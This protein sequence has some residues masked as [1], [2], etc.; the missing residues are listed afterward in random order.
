MSDRAYQEHFKSDVRNAWSSGHRNVCGVMPTGA[1][2]SY[3]VGEI[4]KEH[5]GTTVVI[6][7]RQELVGQLSMSIASNGVQ[8]QIIAPNNVRN[9]IMGE[10]LRELKV[11]MV[12]PNARVAVVGVDTLMRRTKQYARLMAETTMW[13]TDECHHIVRGNKWG[14]VCEMMPNA[15]GLGVTATPIRA[16]GLGLGR[17]A[18][19]VMDVMVEGPTMRELID[20]G[21]L[22]EYRIFAPPSDVDYSHV[23]TGSTGDLKFKQ[24]KSAV[25]ESHLVGDVVEHYK[26]LA[27]GKLGI[28]FATDVETAT[29]IATQFNAAGVPAEVVSAKTPA[30]IRAEIIRRFKARDLLQLVN[31]DL[32][33]EGFDLPAIEVV[34]MARRTLSYSLFSQQF[35]RALRPMPGKDCVSRDTDILTDRGLVKI[36]DITLDHKLWDGVSFVTHSGAVCKGVQKVI[37]FCGLTATPDHEVMTDEGWVTFNDAANRQLR[38][39]ETGIGRK[40]IRFDENNI[41]E[42]N[43]SGAPRW[44]ESTDGGSGMRGVLSNHDGYLQQPPPKAKQNRVQGLQWKTADR[45]PEVVIPESTGAEGS[46]RKPKQQHVEKLRRAWNKIQFHIGKLWCAMDR[47]EFRGEQRTTDRPQRQQRSLRAWESQ[48]DESTHQHEQHQEAGDSEYTAEIHRVQGKIPQRHVCGCHSSATDQGDVR[49]RN[50]KEME[51]TIV[52]TEREVW[53]IHDAGPLQRYTAGGLLVHNCALII[54]H[55]GNVRLHGLPDKERIWSLDSREKRPACK[56]P[57][58]DIPLRY[59]IECTQP[60]ERILV[61]CPWCGH[62]PVP[63]RRDGPEHVDGDLHELTPD[64]LAAMRSDVEAA[65]ES[66]TAV[67][68][69]MRYAGAPEVAWRSAAKR[70]GERQTVQSAARESIAWFAHI[71]KTNGRTDRECYRMFYHQ[72]GIDVL[73][74]QALNGPDSLV[75]A[76]KINE[77]IGRVG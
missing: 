9:F 26:R 38:I 47:A 54:D 45:C 53:D 65:D 50:N 15:L 27:M 66:P 13:V 59:C 41:E 8:H 62:F 49:R 12:N 68:N 22:T 30:K 10:H 34:S 2:K 72:F 58:D 51:H 46:L 39:I 71:Q 31:V 73:S 48:I 40:T 70:V 64:V 32:F 16:D 33:G 67:A 19:G 35:G 77:Y 57:D 36:Q 7:H 42:N 60:Y 44:I 55:A 20:A 75:L 74:A 56:N 24:L 76:N 21:F 6:A 3:T 69:R 23:E 25:K 17:N 5:G 1:G 43:Q 52:Q 4:V 29:D 63:S 37:T 11:N 18:D 28:T 61:A 14:K